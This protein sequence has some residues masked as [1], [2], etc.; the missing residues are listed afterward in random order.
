VLRI[1]PG[2]SV[3]NG[4][5]VHVYR[6]QLQYARVEN[7]RGL[8]TSAVRKTEALNGPDGADGEEVTVEVSNNGWA[9]SPTD[10]PANREFPPV[11]A[12][13]YRLRVA[14]FLGANLA[15]RLVPNEGEIVLANPNGELDWLLD[16]AWDNRT[17]T[18]YQ[19]EWEQTFAEFL[20]Y[21]IGTATGV[22]A[23]QY[24]II[25]RYADKMQVLDKDI[26]TDEYKGLGMAL[27]CD[28][29][30]DFVGMGANGWLWSLEED[31]TLEVL[32]RFYTDPAEKV[33]LMDKSGSTA[34]EEFNRN[35]SLRY[36]CP[37][38]R[39][40][41]SHEYSS[42]PSSE[43]HNSGASTVPTANKSDGLW[44]HYGVKRDTSAKTLEFYVDGVSVGTA[45]Y[46]NQPTGGWR[47]GSRI[48]RDTDD[49]NMD[50]TGD[51]A[52]ARIARTLR[53][54]ED[55]KKFFDRS[56]TDLDSEGLAGVWRLNEGTGTVAGN[57]L[58]Q[59]VWNYAGKSDGV[60]D[61]ATTGTSPTISLPTSFTVAVWLQMDGQDN[62][63]KYI[64]GQGSWG[65]AAEILLRT[66]ATTPGN[67]QWQ[68]K[69]S[70]GTVD[71][72]GTGLTDQSGKLWCLVL[73]FDDDN[74]LVTSYVN[75]DEK[76]QT[77][78]YTR[79]GVWDLTQLAFGSN[80]A[81][82]SN[83]FGGQIF[84]AAIWSRA[85][86]AEEVKDLNDRGVLDLADSAIEVAYGF[87]GWGDLLGNKDFTTT[88]GVVLLDANGTLNGNPEWVGTGEGG[89]DLLGKAKPTISGR[90]H[91]VEPVLLDPWNY[92]YMVAEGPLKEIEAVYEGGDEKALATTTDADIWSYAWP[93]SEVFVVDLTTGLMMAKNQPSYPVTVDVK[94]DDT[95]S[96]YAADAGSIIKGILTRRA[97]FTWPD[98]FNEASFDEIDSTSE[99]G[100]YTD[101]GNGNIIQVINR[102][103]GS[104]HG[105]AFMDRA[106]LIKVAQV[107]VL[108]STA[109]PT[110]EIDTGEI[111]QA[112]I[113]ISP[114]I[115]T[116][117]ETV[118]YA[119][120][121]RTLTDQEVV[122]AAAGKK[123]DLA[124]GFREVTESDEDIK[125]VWKSSVKI[126]SSTLLYSEGPATS[127][128]AAR[129]ARYSTKRRFYTL[130]LP[131]G[132][133]G[134]NVGAIGRLKYPRW[135]IPETGTLVFVVQF[136]E[137]LSNRQVRVLLW[138]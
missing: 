40:E 105:S 74:D 76:V 86:S 125:D 92:V 55:I 30:G 45:S 101:T 109:V 83:F 129:F 4:G 71:Y 111:L 85:L 102:V 50:L 126:E 88:T 103:M 61:G 54:D 53:S 128:S 25:I 49:T 123:A 14:P 79:S 13:P 98:D 132:L 36:D 72:G 110:F 17:I 12:E 51:V 41:Y 124:K 89:I 28:G 81:I 94:G 75:Y 19:G 138:G 63:N 70:T 127:E 68:F 108:D 137:D 115:P 26:Q 96:A 3:Q 42:T 112:S 6:P 67:L 37:N 23:E 122:T 29:T 7:N 47:G 77:W 16:L 82:T 66:A 116:W 60:D 120:Y 97:G 117:R 84:Q 1:F 90:V 119:P 44:H 21:S 113:D 136:E 39:L 121:W 130:T 11:L 133:V 57:E 33:V 20:T 73:T 35:Y 31:W 69:S 10:T 15:P 43:T 87:D 95:G 59:K 8:V 91:H 78:D 114:V 106:A 104:I 56:Q 58:W 46:T 99:L 107:P 48:G 22:A 38:N 32:A 24:V 5:K 52:E 100:V 18:L 62:N 80:A 27:R 131:L 64:F 134:I 135:G 2:L 93:G 118:L 34:G 65:S 9:T